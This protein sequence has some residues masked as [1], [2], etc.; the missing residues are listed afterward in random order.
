MRAAHLHLIVCA[1]AALVPLAT[2]MSASESREFRA[3]DDASFPGWPT[4]FEGRRLVPISP[5]EGDERF[6]SDTGGRVARF[7]LPDAEVLVRWSATPTRH[8]HPSSVCY[9]AIGW[10]IT[11]APR[12]I[13]RDG[14]SW[15]CYLAERDGVTLDVRERVEDATGRSWPDPVDWY[16]A[17]VLG[18]TEGPAFAFTVVRRR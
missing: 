5:R 4:E 6:V 1:V 16:W 8:L 11:P 12:R 17:S 15:S 3:A 9:E 10:T 7:T 14:R 2:R 13:D 18:E